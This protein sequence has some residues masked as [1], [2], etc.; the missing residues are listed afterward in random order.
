[1]VPQ[2]VLNACLQEMIPDQFNKN[3]FDED[4]SDGEDAAA[5]KE[6]ESKPYAQSLMFK[7]GKNLSNNL[8]YV[9]HKK[10]Q[11]MTEEER[12]DLQEKLATSKAEGAELTMRLQ[13]I[14]KETADFLNQPTNEEL[15]VKLQQEE[16]SHEEVAAKLE[17]AGQFKV[18][19]KHRKKLKQK[20]ERMAV[21]WR[22]RRRLV[23]EFLTSLEENTDGSVTR[24]KCLK[25]DGPIFIDSDES[26]ATAAAKFAQDK[27]LKSRNKFQMKRKNSLAGKGTGKQQKES[28]RDLASN[29][30]STLVAVTLDQQ[31]KIVRVHVDD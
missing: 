29:L 21:Y 27:K 9:D 24:R 5:A 14:K 4:D 7:A 8:Y 3:P 12:R 1:M 31:L 26:V 22:Q 6:V 15:V 18:N 23:F 17:A 19:E 30:E 11:A 25:G 10:L 16:A 20:V 13:A 2:P 28:G